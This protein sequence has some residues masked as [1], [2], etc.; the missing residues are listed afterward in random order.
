MKRNNIK[1]KLI[2]LLVIFVICIL[3][4]GVTILSNK[5]VVFAASATDYDFTDELEADRV[6]IG[7]TWTAEDRTLKI[8]GIKN[9]SAIIKLPDNSKID[10]QGNIENTIGG[11]ICEGNLVVKGNDI[12]SLNI[13]GCNCSTPIGY[14]SCVYIYDTLTIENGNLKII[15]SGLGW[16]MS[17]PTYAG[18]YSKKV[19]INGGRFDVNVGG[20]RSKSQ[21]LYA[22]FINDNITINDGNVHIEVK[23]GSG[24]RGETNI[25]GGNIEVVTDTTYSAFKEVPSINPMIDWKIS[26]SNDSETEE[27]EADITDIYNIY[28]SSIIK[29]SKK[30]MIGDINGDGKVNIK[31][32]NRMYEYINE[33]SEFSE[34]EF[35]RGDVNGDGKVNIKDWNRMYEHITEVNPLW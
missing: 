5:S 22:V 33:T 20:L 16:S 14:L 21:I 35:E 23:D 27:I 26:Y 18:I 24:I 30:I 6:G 10:I 17:Q 15:C 4:F 1:K 3:N 12:A 34:E 8:T 13:T 9:D 31:D 29:I 11:L 25:N 7:F 28:N 19:I 32:W 2:M